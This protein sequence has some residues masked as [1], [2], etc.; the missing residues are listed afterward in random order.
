MIISLLSNARRAGTWTVFPLLAMLLAACGGDGGSDS[1]TSA[2]L[3]MPTRAGL[4][5]TVA[6]SPL[7]SPAA[8]PAASPLASPVGSPSASPVSQLSGASTLSREE[9]KAQLAAA[10]PM[11]AAGVEGGQ[12]I[13]GGSGD[14]STTNPMLASDATSINVLGQVFEPLL[15]ASPIDGRP[16]PALA[17]SW[18]VSDDGLVYSFH[19]STTARWHDGV[20]VTADDVAF[21]FD[22]ILDPNLTSPYRGQVREVVDSYRVVDAD[23]FEITAS[24]RFVSFLYNAPGSIFIVPRHIWGEVGRERWSFDGG[25]TGQDVSRI[26]GT[27]PFTFREWTQGQRV[28]LAKNAAYYDVVPHVDEF[29]LLVQAESDVAVRTLEAGDID[30]IEILPA[31]QTKQIQDA[32]GRIVDVYDLY[33]VTFYMTNLDV[34]RNPALADLRVRQA[35]YQAFD[36]D[37]ITSEIFLGFGKSAVGTQPPPSF[38]YAGDELPAYP[39]DPAAAAQLLTDAGWTDTNDDGTVDRDGVELKLSIL[40]TGGDV[41]VDSMVSYMQESWRGIGIDVQLES[42][43]AG[44]EDRLRAGT[45]DLALLAFGFTTEGSQSVLL[46]CE[47]VETGFNFGGY[48]N[49]EVDRLDEAQLREFDPARRRDLLIDQQELIWA[50]LPVSPVRFGVARTGYTDRLHNFYPNSYGFLWSLPYLWV[51]PE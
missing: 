44:L 21:S 17:D 23:T 36:R 33:Q 5:P 3:P 38:A 15:G 2:P 37:Q 6:A 42:I 14:I 9:F 30:I 27:G 51:D 45:F 35:M 4:T 41:T 19:L 39:Y 12:V 7:A 10:Y 11:E 24:D 32:P 40:Y 26:V 16:V 1:P 22:A 31:P 25:S 20:D 46:T 29:V 47:A 8:S 13:L 18:D 50:D 49:P 34:E 43:S 48:C 28:T